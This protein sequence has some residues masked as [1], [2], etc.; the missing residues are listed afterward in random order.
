M[1]VHQNIVDP[2]PDQIEQATLDTWIPLSEAAQNALAALAEKMR[3]R[4]SEECAPSQAE[5]VI[6]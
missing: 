2:T 4:E 6:S 5:A 1:I 3:D